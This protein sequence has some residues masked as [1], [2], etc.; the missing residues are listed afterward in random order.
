M[1]VEAIILAAIDVTKGVG[2]KKVK[3][4]VPEIMIPLVATTKEFSIIKDRI[5][6]IVERE[7]KKAKVKLNYKIGTM[8]EVPRAALVADKLVIAGAEFFS[9]AQT[10]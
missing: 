3:N 6:E 9:L 8:I 1:Q 7:M 5:V 10:T 4:L 2:G